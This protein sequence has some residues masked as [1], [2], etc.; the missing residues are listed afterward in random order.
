MLLFREAMI[1]DGSSIGDNR[2]CIL[3]R[4]GFSCFEVSCIIDKCRIGEKRTQLHYALCNHS[5]FQE[6]FIGNSCEDE[7]LSSL[8]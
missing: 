8:A 2:V 7:F 5:L 1:F 4:D 3:N 6:R